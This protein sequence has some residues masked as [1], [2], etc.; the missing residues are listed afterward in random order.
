MWNK[1]HY[2]Y[3]VQK[4]SDCRF[5]DMGNLATLCNIFRSRIRAMVAAGREPSGSF[6]IGNHK[7]VH[8]LAPRNAP[9]RWERGSDDRHNPS[10]AFNYNAWIR[11][12]LPGAGFCLFRIDQD[13]SFNKK[14]RFDAI[15][16]LFEQLDLRNLRIAKLHDSK[17]SSIP[18]NC[19][20]RRDTVL[21]G[22][23]LWPVIQQHDHQ[24]TLQVESLCRQTAGLG[25]KGDVAAPS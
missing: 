16:R 17:P 8:A 19:F 22:R 20:D 9:P 5:A 10:T 2:R 18:S 12:N 3:E 14:T 15:G 23:F 25:W 13:L 24:H 6:T 4:Q 21:N 11:W 7:T 1:I